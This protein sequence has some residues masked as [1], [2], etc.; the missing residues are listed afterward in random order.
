MRYFLVSFHNLCLMIK[1]YYL[2]NVLSLS[3]RGEIRDNQG[4][5][6]LPRGPV[7][8]PF[9]R[10]NLAQFFAKSKQVAI[11][12][13]TQPELDRYFERVISDFR[14]IDA[15]GGLVCTPSGDT[16]MI[17]RNGRW[18]LPKGK[19]EPG[20]SIE[21]CAVREV[22]EEC[23]IDRLELGALI[24]KTYH[25]YSLEGQMVV[26]RTWWFQMHH[27]GEGALNPQQIEGITKVKWVEK[28]SL[29]CYV[30]ETYPTI[31]DVFMAKLSQGIK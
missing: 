3:L 8:T 30:A 20:E 11:I 14:V 7:D 16:L 5:D 6:I 10:T 17:F 31:Q 2:N 22:S 25:I 26:K 1:I 15:G 24:H 21:Q 19:H 28:N 9:E 13:D 29:V 12:F 4:W 23:G 27:S 18:D